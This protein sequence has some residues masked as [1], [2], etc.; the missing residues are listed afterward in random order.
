MFYE[1]K[2][3]KMYLRYVRPAKIQIRLRFRAVWSESS[4]GVF[5]ITKDVKSLLV[6]NEDTDQTARVCRLIPVFVGRTYQKVCFPSLRFVY[7]DHHSH[8]Q[9]Y[10]SV[11]SCLF[12]ILL[13]PILNEKQC[14]SKSVGFYRSQ[15]IWIYTVCKGK[16]CQFL[17]V[18]V[19]ILRP[20]RPN[21]VMSSAVSLPTHTFTGKA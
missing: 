13:S 2:C 4:L 7:I 17:F 15:L 18:C 16:S 3:R 1:P 12:S 8:P 19:E 10:A 5:W 11:D 20:C 14:R 6:D 21:G 9:V